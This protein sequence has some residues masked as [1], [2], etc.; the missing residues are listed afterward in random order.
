ALE[1]STVQQPNRTDHTFQWKRKDWSLE[2]SE[3]RLTVSIQGD[4]IGYYGYWLK[5]PEAF[6]REYRE[7]RNLA[8][9][10][11]V[12]ASSILVDGSLIIAC[13]F[14][15][16]AMARGQI[17]WRSGLTPAFIV[18]A[19]SLLAQWNTLP[20]AKSYYSTTQNYY[21]FWVQAI[22][23]SLYNAIVRAVPVYFLWAGGQQ[24][25]RRVWP[26]QDMILPRHPSR[27]VTF[28]QAYW[29]GLML[30]GLS[31]AYMVT[32]YL[33]AT[34]VFDTWSPM[35]VD[36]SN[37]FS[38][39]L[40]FMSAL[41]NGILPAIGEELEARLVGI[42]IVLLLL[43]HRWLALLIPGGLWAFAHL[44]YV[45][46]PFY[47]RGIELW[48][49]AIFLYGLFFLRF[50]LL[51]TIVGHCTYN[52]LLGAMLLLKAQDIYLV[53]SGILV[54]ML[55]LLP[56]LPGVWLRWRHPQEWQQALKDERLQLRS[57]MPEDYDQIVSLPLGSV[58][59]PKQLTD[60]RS[61]HCR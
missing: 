38:T 13:L 35:G 51:T 5:I 36:Y 12:N 3:L 23:D 30:A 28:T 1:N 45:S 47:L 43:R 21:L 32:F 16:I 37:L 46:E 40:P 58:T 42:S 39:P 14:Y 26:Q 41:R 60:V 59:L 4:E 44:G 27:L 7:T 18:L 6:T 56:L 54:I 61:C 33:I 9:F 25:A 22:F 17:G 24:L 49:P 48:L 34:Y 10:F 2:D 52:S 29:R 57:A 53:S 8:R 19:V 15:L 55:L 20:L 50:G 11:D 31:M